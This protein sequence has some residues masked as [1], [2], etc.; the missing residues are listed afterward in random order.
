MVS[1]S[2]Y[3]Q[4]FKMFFWDGEQWDDQVLKPRGGPADGPFQEA[5]ALLALWGPSHAL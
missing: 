1:Y 5:W 3:F 4:N 2:L